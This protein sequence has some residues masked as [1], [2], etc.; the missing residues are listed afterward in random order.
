MAKARSNETQRQKAPPESSAFYIATH[1]T[2]YQEYLAAISPIV[3][4]FGGMYLVR[5][6][7][8]CRSRASSR[9]AGAS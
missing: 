1:P 6:G 3:E 8:P 5:G 7:G 2:G 9:M 4:K